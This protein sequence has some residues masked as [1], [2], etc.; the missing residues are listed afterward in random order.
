MR[1]RPPKDLTSLVS[2]FVGSDGTLYAK[3]KNFIPEAAY[4]ALAQQLHTDV[5]ASN[6][7]WFPVPGW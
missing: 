1:N 6:Q 2:V 5:H 7:Q 3:S 4:D